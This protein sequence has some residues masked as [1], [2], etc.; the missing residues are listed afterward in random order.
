MIDWKAFDDYNK[1][2]IKWWRKAINR[3][4]LKEYGFGIKFYPELE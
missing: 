2:H 1:A 3:Y 4:F